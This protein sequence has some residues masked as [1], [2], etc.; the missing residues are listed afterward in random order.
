MLD[1]QEF[2]EEIE[3]LVRLA[4]NWKSKEAAEKANM[5]IK[6]YEKFHNDTHDY[7]SARMEE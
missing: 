3:A 4:V 5:L 7:V 1:P 6:M 2:S